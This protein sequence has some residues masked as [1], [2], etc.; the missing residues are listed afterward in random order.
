[1]AAFEE[2]NY[3]SDIVKREFDPFMNRETGTLGAGNLKAG[4]VLGKL[5]SGGNYVAL[6]PAAS[7][8][9]Q[10]V[11]G[12]LLFDVDASGGAQPCVVLARGPA[13]V[14]EASLIFPN[15]NAGQITAAKA[16]L[17]AMGIVVRTTLQGG[18]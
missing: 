14:A 6:D 8:G 1:M 16:A 12:V 9:A 7:T 3:V 2:G 10:T 11:S 18:L 4:T 15:G 5:T 17:T 13:V